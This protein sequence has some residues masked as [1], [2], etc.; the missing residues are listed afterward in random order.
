MSRNPS[1]PPAISHI[2]QSAA[3]A[4]SQLEAAAS[5]TTLPPTTTP[6]PVAVASSIF[7]NPPPPVPTISPAAAASA[8]T[9]ITH[10][11][12]LICQE[13]L[14]TPSAPPLPVDTVP[15][16]PVAREIHIAPPIVS[17]LSHTVSYHH[18]RPLPQQPSLLSV[19]A[20]SYASVHESAD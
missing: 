6:S 2:H 12:P 10:H 13:P 14:P 3:S 18:Y 20:A 17:P 4:I 15:T 16:L 7:I 8:S 1:A 11:P 5:S 19:Q 9:T